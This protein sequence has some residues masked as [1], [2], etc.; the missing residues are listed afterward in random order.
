MTIDEILSNAGI[1]DPEVIEAVKA[2]MPKNF[3]PLADANKRIAAAK[4]DAEAKAKALDDYKAEQAKALE[5]AAKADQGKA[6]ALEAL[7]AQHEALQKQFA[8]AQEKAKQTA[9]RE[10]LVKALKDAGANPAAVELMAS[11][12]LAGIEYDA[13]GK[14]SNVQTVTDALKEGNAGLFGTQLDTGTP[15]KKADDANALLDAF[16]MGFGDTKRH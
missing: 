16:D 5:D 8:A 12:A 15:G 1:T 13:D 2:E 4:Q 7:K 11:S 10:A 9:G 6:D 14:P 3:M